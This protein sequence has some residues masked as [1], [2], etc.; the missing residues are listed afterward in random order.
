MGALF[1][2]IVGPSC[3]TR[4]TTRTI[5]N[6]TKENAVKVSAN[7]IF[8]ISAYPNPSATEFTVLLEGGSKE[9]VAII[10]TDLVG[11]KVYQSA[12]DMKQQYKFGNNLMPGIYML[13]VIQGNSKQSIKL[14]KE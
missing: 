11:R 13:Q 10:V 14:I 3:I 12:G 2:I 5:V 9:K 7:S 4:N 6:T 1:T 8:K